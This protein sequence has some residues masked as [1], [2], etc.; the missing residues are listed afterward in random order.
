M[1]F[2]V[3]MKLAQSRLIVAYVRIIDFF[4]EKLNVKIVDLDLL[5]E[6]ATIKFLK[7]NHDVLRTLQVTG[8]Y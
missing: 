5:A 7:S 8:V 3:I 4:V 1:N 6:V 2:Q